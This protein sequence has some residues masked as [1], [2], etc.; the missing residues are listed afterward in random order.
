[1]G[2]PN[3]LTVRS[4]AKINWN[5]RVLRK[6]EDGFHEIESLISTV[7]LFDELSFGRAV[8]GAV[9][10][11]CDGADLP[12]DSSNLI[13]QAGR[14]L[15][16]RY[17]TPGGF[18]CGLRKRIPIGGGLGGGSSNAAATLIALNQL[19]GLGATSDDLVSIAAALGSDV[20]LFLQ[21]GT[22]VVSGRG[23]QVHRVDLPFDGWIVLMMPDF[24]VSTAEVYRA[25]KPAAV[26]SPV[27]PVPAPDAKAWMAQTYNM[28]EAPCR[29]VSPGMR[30][31][32]DA[33][34][35]LANRA[36]RISGSGSTLFTAFD[37]EAEASVFAE[38][39]RKGLSVATQVVRVTD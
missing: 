29:L 3:V 23:E 9:S 34:T 15:A 35:V 37:A 22:V 14:L 24:G 26:K 2:E 18:T 39:A 6:R 1:M 12:T 19:W 27:E 28:L 33:A 5:L 30:E 10:L 31:L 21:P 25:W 20:A 17:E 36:V 11:T 8:D 7:T 38:S 16:E 32:Q 4:P 13:V